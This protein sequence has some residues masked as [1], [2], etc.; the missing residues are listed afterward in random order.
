MSGFLLDANVLIAL[1]WPTHVAHVNVGRWFGRH[2]SQGWATCPFT[3]CGFIRI[4]SNPKFSP[5]ALAVRD[6]VRLLNSTIQHPKHRFWPDELD[7]TDATHGFHSRLSGHQQI[8]DAYLLGLALH[9]GGKLAT[10]DRSI[11]AL[12]PPNSA[13]TRGIEL[14]PS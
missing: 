12:L 10:L 3:Q 13:E 2:A 8:T 11:L 6:A 7:F 1:T 9:K 14:I 4:I 5:D